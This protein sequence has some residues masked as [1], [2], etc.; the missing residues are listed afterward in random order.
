[1]LDFLT[2]Q[3]SSIAVL[4]ICV[5]V[6]VCGAHREK[7]AAVFWLSGL[8]AS[9]IWNAFWPG[10]DIWRYM[11]IDAAILLGFVTL[12]WKAP[13]PWPLWAC[14]LQLFSLMAA[15]STLKTPEFSNDSFLSLRPILGWGVVLAMSVGTMQAL[16]VRR[17]EVS[18]QK[19]E[20]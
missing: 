3:I 11:V 17:R 20:T 19:S 6:L 5:F 9:L 8:G 16:R 10:E 13:H 12:C 1:M 2:T 18:G 4:S 15:V 14:G 7:M